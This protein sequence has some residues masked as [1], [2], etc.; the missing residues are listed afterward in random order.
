MKEGERKESRM[1]APIHLVPLEP[2]LLHASSMVR[3]SVGF[4]FYESW[5]AE[6]ELAP[7]VLE[8]CR[9]YGE[10]ASLN[11]LSF[12]CRFP[13]SSRGLVEA[14]RAV[15]RSRPPFVEQWV[16]LAPLSLTRGRAELLRSV[17]S[18]RAIARLE[19]RTLFH[20]E[21]TTELWR[22]LDGLCRKLDARAV[23]PGERD[24]IDDLLEALSA[25]ER[26]DGVAKRV[27]ALQ[28]SASYLRWALVELSGVMRLSELGENLVD[29]LE[30]GEDGIARA[31]A[32][33]L[34]RVGSTPVVSSIGA[35]YAGGSRRF[36][37]F[38]LSVLKAI[39]VEASA[40]LL[41]D[42]AEDESDPALRGR[43]F[44][45]LRFQFS[46]RSEELL[47]RELEHPSSWMISGEI[48]KALYV[49]AALKGGP[50][51]SPLSPPLSEESEIYFHL[52][53]AESDE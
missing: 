42:L 10:E 13:L 17:L 46:D 53:F 7:L 8:A 47:R 30:T 44:D 4:H 11:L 40:A 37:R 33:A 23:E 39:K 34:A 3:D 29:L 48:G 50:A 26:R 21:T 1:P 45:A 52:P 18:R 35:R 24:E 5:S 32:Q 43:V 14:L 6:E 28:E 15:A 25:L 38:A 16:S 20:R 27:L 2:F 41:A 19:R 36:R 31:A 12:G 9:R 22:R 49:F 51:S